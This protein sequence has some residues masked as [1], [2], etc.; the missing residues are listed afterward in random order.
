M[1]KELKE[2]INIIVAEENDVI[3]AEITAKLNDAAAQTVDKA[4]GNRMV[5]YTSQRENP[6]N[7]SYNQSNSVSP[8]IPDA[9]D[10]TMDKADG[11]RMVVHPKFERESYTPFLQSIRECFTNNTC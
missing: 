5:V 1:E 10:E 3:A 7:P 4:Y 11:N 8:T 6:R 2:G 9:M